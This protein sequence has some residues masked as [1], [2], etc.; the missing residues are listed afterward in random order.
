MVGLKVE[1]C[2]EALPFIYCGVDMVCPY[3]IKEW[4]SHL[5]RYGVLFTCFTCRTI[6]IVVTYALDTNFFILTLRR[7][8]IRRDVVRSIWSDN[9]TNFVG[10]RN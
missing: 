6:H 9:G 1:R 7:F 3:L 5:K 2:T 10:I 4:I 8:M